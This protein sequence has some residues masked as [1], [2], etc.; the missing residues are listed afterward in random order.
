[1][2][3]RIPGL[4]ARAIGLFVVHPSSAIVVTWVFGFSDFLISDSLLFFFCKTF[5][6]S[7]LVGYR[8]INNKGVL[9]R[10]WTIGKVLRAISSTLK[11]QFTGSHENEK[12]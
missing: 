10:P 9:D 11:C 8:G 1:M 7:M 4:S 5:L 6:N 3:M 12:I 2:C